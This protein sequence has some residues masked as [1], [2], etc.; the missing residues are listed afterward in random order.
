MRRDSVLRSSPFR[1][2]LAIGGITALSMGAAGSVAWLQ[3]TKNLRGLYDDR[4]AA[5]FD[6][7]A[8][9]AREPDGDGIRE[10]VAVYRFRVSEDVPLVL[11]QPDDGSPA[12][13]NMPAIDIPPGWSFLTAAQLGKPGDE[14]YR[15]LSREVP[16]GRLTLAQLDAENARAAAHVLQAILWGI[17]ASLTIGLAGGALVARQVRQRR[18]VFDDTLQAIGRGDLSARIPISPAEDDLDALSVSINAALA[19]LEALVENMQQVTADIAHDLRTPLSRLNLRLQSAIDKVAAGQ[20][21]EEDLQVAAASC[22]EI[23]DTFSAILRIAQ[24]EAGA[25]KEQFADLDLAALLCGVTEFYEA[26]AEEAGM[27]LTCEVPEAPAMVF[28]ERELLTQVAVNLIENAIRHCPAGTAIRCRVAA[29]RA[30]VRL[31]VRDNGPGIPA[32]ERDKV[33]RRFYRLDKSRNTTGSGLGLS[34][35]HA[36]AELHGATLELGDAAPGLLVTLRFPTR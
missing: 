29:D 28:G 21:V 34:L 22:T 26:A 16:G 31:E 3:L 32:A 4:V 7:V 14:T 24:I 9:A 33:V 11:W 12:L 2:A 23:A 27:T 18:Q 30:G 8:A 1:A 15:V 5:V 25:R 10:L 20:D 13:G 19:R 36:I 35:V 6:T 17:L